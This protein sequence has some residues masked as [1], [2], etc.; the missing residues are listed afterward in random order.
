M[1]NYPLNDAYTI[2][3]NRNL[4]LSGSY[5]EYISEFIKNYTLKSDI[6]K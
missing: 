2:M 4:L 5:A 6:D 3:I 1:C